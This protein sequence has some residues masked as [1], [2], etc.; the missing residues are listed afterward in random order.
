MKVLFIAF[1]S[2][3]LSVRT[4]SAL[5][6]HVD[7]CLMLPRRETEPHLK[8]LNDD[9]RYE[10]FEKPRLR[11]TLRQIRL[12]PR[13]IRRICRYRP[14][15]IHFQ[16]GHLYFNLSLPLMRQF[17]LVMSIHD[18]QHHI[19]DKGQ[20]KTPQFVMDFA[21]RRAKHVIAHN[22]AMKNMTIKR[23]GFSED[24][25][26]IVPLVER[27]D[28]A[29]AP[30]IKES[31]NEVLFFGRIWKYKGLDYL[32]RAEPLITQQ[33]PDVKFVIAG[34]GDDFARY[35]NAMTHPE[36]F[37]VHNEFVSYDKQAELFRRASVIVLPYIEATQSGVIPLAY[38]YGK[39]VV[40]SAVG[41]LP[42]Q[43]EDGK[44]GFLVPPSDS[45]ALADKITLLLQDRAL[46][47]RLGENG[48]QKLTSEWS[49][50]VVA[51]KT[52]DVYHKVLSDGSRL[53]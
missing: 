49:A 34:K 5:A 18:P 8:W 46:R 39:P 40:A 27:G 31:G 16:K 15:V 25:I 52:V 42:S 45:R 44:T 11:Q 51:R 47:Q 22:E 23:F 29:A 48:R 17:P 24:H 1:D 32:I 7:V 12:M 10:P 53:N 6:E 3:E 13:L 19:G 38:T 14:D 35:R 33:V 28:A 50:D 30:H 37:E 26:S 21:Y 4:A 43:V 2:A 41:G 9:V 20:A 36:R